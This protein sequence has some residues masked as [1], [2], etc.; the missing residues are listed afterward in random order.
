MT[1]DYDGTTAPKMIPDAAQLRSAARLAAWL[2]QEY[3]VPL[4]RV[5]GHR[6][7]WPSPPSAPANT[8][9]PGDIEVQAVQQERPAAGNLEHYLLFW[10]RGGSSRHKPTGG[11][12]AYLEHFRTTAASPWTMHFSPAM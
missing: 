3:K 12:Q 10:G 4:E 5:M 7:V 1:K 2:M 8:G 9:R 11:T 6:D